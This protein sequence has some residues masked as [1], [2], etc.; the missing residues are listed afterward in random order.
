MSYSPA[1]PLLTSE[2]IGTLM[3]GLAS[4]VCGQVSGNKMHAMS[5]MVLQVVFVNR[6]LETKCTQC[7]RLSW[8][9][10]SWTG[11]WKQNAHN[12]KI[13]LQ[14][15]FVDRSLETKYVQCQVSDSQQLQW[16]GGLNA[17]SHVTSPGAIL[18]Q[19]TSP[20]TYPSAMHFTTSFLYFP[21][22]PLPSRTWRNLDLSIP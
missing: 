17:V 5:Q 8:K 15:V 19:G 3:D 1:L 22:S 18:C 9:L 10:C 20:F 11:L 12:V 21:C 2:S 13:V 16:C 14:V 7:H 6:S 4:C